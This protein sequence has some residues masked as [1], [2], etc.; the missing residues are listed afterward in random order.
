MTLIRVEFQHYG[1][2]FVKHGYET[3]A[4]N[5]CQGEKNQMRVDSYIR[6]YVCF[7]RV[8]YGSWSWNVQID[9]WELPVESLKQR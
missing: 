5:R 4:I 8:N 9:S 2:A 1:R 3:T 7:I 6:A